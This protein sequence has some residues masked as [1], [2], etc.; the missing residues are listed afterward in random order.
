MRGWAAIGETEVFMYRNRIVGS[1]EFDRAEA[2]RALATL[3]TAVET[4]EGHRAPALERWWGTLAHTKCPDLT[5]RLR[6][7]HQ[8]VVVE[9]S[10]GDCP[11]FASQLTIDAL[12]ALVGPPEST[13]RRVVPGSGDDR[14]E[15]LTLYQYGKGAVGFVESNFGPPSGSGKYRVIDRVLFDPGRVA[16]AIDTAE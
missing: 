2:D 12:I 7:R 3:R 1:R 11:F 14:T 15:V 9:A 13:A 5:V 16:K 6:R 8:R 4:D 10:G